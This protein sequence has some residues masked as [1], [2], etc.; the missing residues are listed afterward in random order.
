VCVCLSVASG[1]AGWLHRFLFTVGITI[2]FEKD[3]N[4]NSW[5]SSD[6]WL[7]H[8]CNSPVWDW[9]WRLTLLWLKA[10]YVIGV[11]LDC[12]NWINFQ[13]CRNSVWHIIQFLLKGWPGSIAADR[14]TR[15]F[16]LLSVHFWCKPDSRMR[17]SDQK[18]IKGDIKLLII[19]CQYNS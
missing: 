19:L 15:R 5:V 3:Q 18:D 8:F 12:D 14:L 10:N 13:F 1:C 17:A 4:K 2:M 9:K 7:D 11:I 16:V 6:V